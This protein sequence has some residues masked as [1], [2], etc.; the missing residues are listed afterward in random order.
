MEN[1][2]LTAEQL[3]AL[4]GVTPHWVRKRTR[5]RTIPAINL[6]A[7]QPDARTRPLWRYEPERVLAALRRATA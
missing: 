2:L 1:T 6:R 4:L 7:G 5:Q 3:A